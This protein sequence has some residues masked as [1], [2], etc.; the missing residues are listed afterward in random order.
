MTDRPQNGP[1]R[2][3]V[4]TSYLLAAVAV[5]ALVDV[6]ISLAA[7][8]HLDASGAAY[9]ESAVARQ[10]DDPERLLRD[11]AAALR[12]NV[13]VAAAVAVAGGALALVVRRRSAAVRRLVWIVAGLGILLFGCGVAATPNSLV[14]M[15]DGTPLAR[16]AELDLLPQWHALVRGVLTSLELVLLLAVCGLLMR[17]SAGEHYHTVRAGAERSL[18]D[19]LLERR[20]REEREAEAAARD[21]P[22]DG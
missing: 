11:L 22:A 2:S 21:R 14:T 8:S 20:R 1:P 16:L 3:V 15:E 12:Q 17:S 4:V 7:R 6:A 13:V 9:L 18:G 5:I 19:I 10:L